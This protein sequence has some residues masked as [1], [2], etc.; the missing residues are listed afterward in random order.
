MKAADTHYQT[1]AWMTGDGGSLH[2]GHG[3]YQ[4]PHA[5]YHLDHSL[6]ETAKAMQKGAV[7]F[8]GCKQISETFFLPLATVE[9]PHLSMRRLS[10]S[11][12]MA[13]IEGVEPFDND[14]AFRVSILATVSSKPKTTMQSS[15]GNLNEI[16]KTNRCTCS[17]NAAG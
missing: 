7:G 11:R 16:L 13:H 15:G 5:N 10:T 9:F 6:Q 8:E 4:F 14:S 1:L 17:V 3:L 12:L 2:F